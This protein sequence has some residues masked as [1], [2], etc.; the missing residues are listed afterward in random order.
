MP[1]DLRTVAPMVAA[2]FAG[3]AHLMAG[4]VYLVSGLVVPFYALL[5]LWAWWL[6]LLVTLVRLA[7]RGS[8][9]VVAVPVV[10]A[11]TWVLVVLGGGELLDWTA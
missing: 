10:A 1:A 11:V 5:P 3:V 2:G 9:W 8:W 6:F 7:I 4:Y